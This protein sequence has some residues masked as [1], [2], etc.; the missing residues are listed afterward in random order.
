MQKQPE[1]RSG[2]KAGAVVLLAGLVW[3]AILVF[4]FP[5]PQPHERAAV[6]LLEQPRSMPGSN[7]YADLW[8]LDYA[9]PDE[10]VEA[11]LQ[12]DIDSLQALL[13]SH[14]DLAEEGA[15]F[16]ATA[17]Q[18]YPRRGQPLSERPYCGWRD[19]QDC[20]SRVRGEADTVALALQQDAEVLRILEGLPAHGH[21][22][23]RFQRTLLTPVPELGWLRMV[24][25]ASA[26]DFA[27]GRV[28]QAL[29]RSCRNIGAAR[30]LAGHSDDLVMAMV[31]DAQVRTGTE[32]LAQMLAELPLDY[33][34]PDS[35]LAAFAP[36]LATADICRAIAGEYRANQNLFRR[37]P[38][39][40][41][42]WEEK[43]LMKLAYRAERS[44]HRAAVFPAEFCQP[45]LLQALAE[46]Q[47][48][49]RVEHEAKEPVEFL[50]TR[51]C[52]SNPV[53]CILVEVGAGM[54]GNYLVRR[55]QTEVVVRLMHRLLMVRAAAVDG[56]F[57]AAAMQP[58]IEHLQAFEV[59]WQAAA[60][61]QGLCINWQPE[62]PDA[63]LLSLPWP[64]SRQHGEPVPGCMEDDGEGRL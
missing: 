16:T 46:A 51:A 64:G 5:G 29:E 39:G 37:L 33:P 19:Q 36:A 35:C 28:Q 62:R 21:V 31:M 57:D 24:H 22:R 50:P 54:G 53:G 60:N 43:L 6:A 13:D 41:A 17:Q 20:L 56:A 48:L 58:A 7:A 15:F 27:E 45:S 59:P 52:L 12:A 30:R 23:N 10:A 40:P 26:L 32:V 47:V 14:A 25:T 8:R 44:W 42:P 9:M 3:A 2:G 49:Q 55:Q 18:Y 61:R 38:D 4:L 11:M 1:R 34:L 63:R